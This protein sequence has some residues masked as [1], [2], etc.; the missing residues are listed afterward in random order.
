M[1]IKTNQNASLKEAR[2]IEKEL[3]TPFSQSEIPLLKAGQLFLA[4]QT[5]SKTPK[6]KQVHPLRKRRRAEKIAP[7]CPL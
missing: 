6:R 7:S 4:L 1:I 3:L 2:V 5:S